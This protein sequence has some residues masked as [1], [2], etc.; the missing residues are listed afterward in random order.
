M[1]AWWDN[2]VSTLDYRIWTSGTWSAELMG[3]DL[4]GQI[5]IVQLVPNPVTDVIFL[6]TKIH[7][8]ANEE[9]LKVTRWNGSAWG[10]PVQI[11]LE[12]SGGHAESF[13]VSF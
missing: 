5:W 1:V 8:A 9:N 11:E 13:M 7:P 2:G 12:S 4:G 3:P 6:S 10:T